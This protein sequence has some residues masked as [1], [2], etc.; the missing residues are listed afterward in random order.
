MTPTQVRNA[1]M[2]RFIAE[3]TGRFPIAID[4]QEEN[5]ADTWVR[6]TVKF[7]D[8]NQSSLGRVSNRKFARKGLIAAQVFT[9]KNT[10]TDENDNLS[11]ECLE[12]FDGVRLTDLHM[13]NGKID[14]VGGGDKYY[15]QNVVIEF[16]FYNIR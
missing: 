2:A 16:E 9:K 6:L 13:F 4:N 3:F 5:K 7:N 15:Q 14:T 1:I 10:G 12:L 11:Q 8:G